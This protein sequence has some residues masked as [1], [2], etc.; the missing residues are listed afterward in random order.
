MA[1]KIGAD[2]K[3]FTKEWVSVPPP[4]PTQSVPKEREGVGAYVV[5]VRDIVGQFVKHDAGCKD[6]ERARVEQREEEEFVVGPALRACVAF[7]FRFAGYKGTRFSLPR[8]FFIVFGVQAR[9]RERLTTQPPPSQGQ[10]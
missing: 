5:N 3:P 9:A 2:W 8:A 10:W 7:A 6:S 1:H 4:P